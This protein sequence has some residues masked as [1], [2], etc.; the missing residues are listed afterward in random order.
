MTTKLLLERQ[1]EYDNERTTA[2]VVVSKTGGPIRTIIT[3]R[4]HHATGRI[5]CLKAGS[6]A[7]PWE[8]MRGELPA[9]ILAEVASPVHA[10]MVQPHRLEMRVE[11]SNHPLVYFPDLALAVDHRAIDE[12]AGHQPFTRGLAAWKPTPGKRAEISTLI[13]EIKDDRDPRADDEQYRNKLAIAAKVYNQL[14]WHFVEL[15]RTRDIE[16]DHVLAASRDIVANAYT[17]VDS[18]DVACVAEQIEA[19]GG[20]GSH[21]ALAELL[22]GPRLGRAKLAALHVRRVISI[23]LSQPVRPDSAVRMVDDGGSLL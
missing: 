17:R 12:L 4:K 23:D 19:S 15:V 11:G 3:G 8:S 13:I 21:S 7:M 2:R 9:I 14:G 18:V 20:I 1:I 22:G 10:L 16:A 5:V 6:R